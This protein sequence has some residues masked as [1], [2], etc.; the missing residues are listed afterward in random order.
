MYGLDIKA[1]VYRDTVRSL[2]IYM[3][4]ILTGVESMGF[5]VK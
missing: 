2:G 4:G 1:V 3:R 5:E